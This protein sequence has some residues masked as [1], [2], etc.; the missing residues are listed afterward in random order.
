MTAFYDE[1][2]FYILKIKSCFKTGILGLP[3]EVFPKHSSCISLDLFP[4]NSEP[5]PTDLTKIQLK[6]LCFTQRRFPKVDVARITQNLLKYPPSLLFLT[7]KT[8]IQIFKLSRQFIHSWMDS[9][10]KI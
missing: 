4:T 5:A 10:T 9:I 7:L 2:T 6:Y 3:L 1:I 8:L